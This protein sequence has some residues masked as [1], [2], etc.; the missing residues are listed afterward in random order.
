V[1]A[2]VKLVD[3]TLDSELPFRVEIPT[4]TEIVADPE[5]LVALD[6]VIRSPNRSN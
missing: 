3:P 1:I 4:H 2:V 6:P 5:E